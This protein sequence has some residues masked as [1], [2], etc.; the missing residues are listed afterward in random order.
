M[1]KN[2]GRKH[3]RVIFPSSQKGLSFFSENG[4]AKCEEHLPR[5]APEES[6]QGKHLLLAILS[7]HRD[8]ED[9]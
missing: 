7:L 9:V 2:S 1:L 8:L 6:L 5:E 3:L 4:V